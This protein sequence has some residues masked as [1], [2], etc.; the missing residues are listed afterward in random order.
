MSLNLSI[1]ALSSMNSLSSKQCSLNLVCKR[2]MCSSNR[3]IE[4]R[5]NPFEVK[6]KADSKKNKKFFF[7]VEP[8]KTNQF[9]FRFHR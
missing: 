4:R 7:V 2:K 5:K 3:L 1:G 8:L 6:K 9:D